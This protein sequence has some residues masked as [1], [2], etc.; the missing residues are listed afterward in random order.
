RYIA[1][2]NVVL[3]IDERLAASLDVPQRR[4]GDGFIFG[5][6]KRRRLRREAAIGRGDGACFSAPLQ[7]SG[8]AHV[9]VR[10]AGNKHAGRECLRD[11]RSDVLAPLRLATEVA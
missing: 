5:F 11:E 8:E 4:Y 1:G 7:T 10:S 6:G 2:R 3:E 9:A